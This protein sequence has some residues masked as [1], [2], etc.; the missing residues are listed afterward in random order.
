VT[1]SASHRSTPEP[2]RNND[3]TSSECRPANA[4]DDERVDDGRTADAQQRGHDLR[5]EDRHHGRRGRRH[6]QQPDDE[7]RDE[8]QDLGQQLEQRDAHGL[9]Q[10]EH[11]GPDAAAGLALQVGV[12]VAELTR[13]RGEVV[14]LLR[15]RARVGAALGDLGLGEGLRAQQVAPELLGLGHV[16]RAELAAQPV[17]VDHLVDED[18]RQRVAVAHADLA[19][20]PLLHAGDAVEQQR[21]GGLRPVDRREVGGGPDGERRDREARAL[22]LRAR[23]PRMAST[24]SST[25]RISSAGPTHVVNTALYMPRVAWVMRLSSGSSTLPPSAMR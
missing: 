13:D 4:P 1:S 2:G 12:A 10:G 18:G 6:H 17:L 3:T 11:P 19:E 20:E 5:L 7:H 16:G 22:G 24:N 9:D 8:D 25:A 14:L 21:I 23:S 15:R